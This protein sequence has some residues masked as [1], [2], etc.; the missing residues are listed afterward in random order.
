MSNVDGSLIKVVIQNL[1]LRLYGNLLPMVQWDL[2]SY[3]EIQNT[4]L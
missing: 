4:F 3:T 1:S 2:L